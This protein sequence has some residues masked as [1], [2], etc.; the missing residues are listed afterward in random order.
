[1]FLLKVFTKSTNLKNLITFLK[2]YY[3]ESG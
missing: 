2:W 1:M 3:M